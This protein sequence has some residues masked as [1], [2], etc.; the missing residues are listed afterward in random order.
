[1]QTLEYTTQDKSTW[2][3]GPWQSEPDKM[4]Y[5]DE[6]T[7]LPCLIVRNPYGALCG[8]VGVT[9]G[10]PFFM[11]NGYDFPLSVHGGITFTSLCRPGDD[12]AH[13]IC[14]IPGPGEPDHVWW[15]GFD[16]SHFN[17]T[18]P[19][20]EARMRTLGVPMP[21]LSPFPLDHIYFSASYKTIEYVKAEIASLAHQLN[22]VKG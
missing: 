18:C 10:H 15:L 20:M 14:H 21:D 7:G 1:M 22:T 13:G 8:Y 6:A 3:E 5:K 16:C 4:Q 2:G 19:G 11:K 12:E 9:E 17:D